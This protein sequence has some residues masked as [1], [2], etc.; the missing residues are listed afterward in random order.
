MS[1]DDGR[2]WND[3][4]KEQRLIAKEERE[5]EK[6]AHQAWID[7]GRP[8]KPVPEAVVVPKVEELYPPYFSEYHSPNNKKDR[9]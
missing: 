1:Y 2:D 4:A 8:I 6:A 5:A 9:R 7:A 3:Y